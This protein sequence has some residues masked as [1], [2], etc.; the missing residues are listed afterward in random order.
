[1]FVKFYIKQENDKT[2]YFEPLNKTYI[3][4]YL[5]IHANCSFYYMTVFIIC[6]IYTKSRFKIIVGHY[7]VITQCC[8]RILPVHRARTITIQW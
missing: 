8:H 5:K 1:M 4:N 3:Q 6:N 7:K 2:S